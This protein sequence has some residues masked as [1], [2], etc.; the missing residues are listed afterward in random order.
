MEQYNAKRA[1]LSGIID[2]A[3]TFPPAALPFVD[4]L[5]EAA[6][7]RSELRQPWLY[8]KMALNL[9]LLKSV[10]ARALIS[11][12]ADGTPWVFTALGS[13]IP[14]ETNAQEFARIIEWDLREIR[15]FNERGTFS[16]CRQSIA[17]YETRIPLS[18]LANPKSIG[19][20]LAPA[21]ER[22]TAVSQGILPYF[23]LGLGADWR[24]KIENTIHALAGWH[25]E[26]SDA[27]TPPG[28]K[29]RTGGQTPCTSEQLA[30]VIV[31]ATSYRLRFKATQGLHHALTQKGVLGFVNVF[32][33][34]NL[35]QALGEE[36]F[37]RAKVQ[38]CLNS[39]SASD[40]KFTDDTFSWREHSLDLEKIEAAR[41]HHAGC[42]GSCSLKEPDEFLAA[43]LP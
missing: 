34:L 40:F 4:A 5:K 9:E 20:Y 3:G 27:T 35:A 43:E 12:G 39:E 41:R 23:E 16:S 26:Q 29:I 10:N 14:E 11:A 6:T 38:A 2:Y 36:G 7:Y 37:P 42:F 8:A 32:A 21:L 30:D 17:A 25:S 22:V 33:A 28:I 13:K 24:A 19:E 15:R 1:L 18:A 31:T